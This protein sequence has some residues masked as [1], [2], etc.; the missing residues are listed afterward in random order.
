M[1]KRLKL[2]YLAQFCNIARI[3]LKHIT[4][5][6]MDYN[7]SLSKNCPD[8]IWNERFIILYKMDMQDRF[9]LIAVN[10]VLIFSTI[11]LNLISVITIRKS[12]QLKNK[13]CYFVILVQ[14]AVDCVG[15]IS[16]IP[17]FMIILTMPSSGLK[18]CLVFRL[19]F[20]S[21]LVV[22]SLAPVSLSAM[23]AERYIGVLHPYSYQSLVTKRRVLIYV[24]VA[25]FLCAA[26]AIFMFNGPRISTTVIM[27]TFFLFTAYA[28]ARIY[29]V[30]R[31]L[32]RLESRPANSVSKDNHSRRRCL[33]R[34]IKHAKCC[35]IVVILYGVFM[36][37]S[38]LFTLFASLG[39]NR[40]VYNCWLFTLYIVNSSINSVIFFWTKTL[41]RAEAWKIVKSIF[42]RMQ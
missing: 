2:G 24:G 15:G 13:I 33:L 34:E 7:D 27:F 35:F 20:V 26:H 31:K 28:Y 39:V 29:L 16:S 10:A 23:T 38:S 12:S 41:L 42:S 21:M 6:D 11:F 22:P 36:L 4:Q 18:N 8:K 40:G 3:A 14:S 19:I 32:D 5:F 30:V 1:Y 17:L 9:L 37:P 25:G